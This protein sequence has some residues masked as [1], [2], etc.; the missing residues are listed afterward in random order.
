MSKF[1]AFTITSY[2]EAPPATELPDGVKYMVYQQE[3]C[4]S[5]NRLHW[6]GYVV[7]NSPRSEQSVRRS[8]H[9]DHIEVA[10]GTPDQNFD[11]CTKDDT[12]LGTRVELGVRPQP[13]SRTDLSTYVKRVREGATDADLISECPGLVA[14]YPKFADHIREAFD[15]SPQ[16]RDVVV[17]L[18]LGETGLGKSHIANVLFPGA[19]WKSNESR[20][21][22]RYRGERVVI[23]DDFDPNLVSV[24]QL[25]RLTDV[26]PNTLDIKHKS[27]YARYNIL[28]LTSNLEPREWYP[29]AHA[30]HYPALD[31]R[32]HT[33]QFE[34][35]RS[36]ERNGHLARAS[37]VAQLPDALKSLVAE[38]TSPD[39]LL[40]L[41]DFDLSSLS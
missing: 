14:K 17:F 22:E 11:Y 12:S 26:Y 34:T 18:F 2:K 8:F 20:F 10:R 23:W 39:P 30:R 9:P 32:I 1:R 31:R 29:A 21:W 16:R 25:L 15:P 38:L 41:G 40:T 3:R 6:Q 24:A 5:T 7:Y 35:W 19:Y 36:K 27:T 33:V 13:G 37:V 28:V 4:P